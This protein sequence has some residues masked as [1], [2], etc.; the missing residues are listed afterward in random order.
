MSYEIKHEDRWNGIGCWLG[1]PAA[2][3]RGKTYQNVT[4]TVA[5][6][7]EGVMVD[8]NV[9]AKNGKKCN[10]G[11]I[12]KNGACQECQLIQWERVSYP[13]GWRYG[14]G[15]FVGTEGFGFAASACGTCFA[16]REEAVSEAL[17]IISD[18]FGDAISNHLAKQ[19][20]QR[21][22]IFQQLDLFGGLQ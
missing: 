5:Y 3:W 1:A 10:C 4:I 21:P 13:A 12:C 22:E 11:G 17:R 2:E 20:G 6:L 14:C 18:K 15:G 7:P 8:S 9:R 19:L 16:T